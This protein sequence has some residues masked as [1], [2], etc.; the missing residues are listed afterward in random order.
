MIDKRNDG[1][2]R[3]WS[4][5]LTIALTIV[6]VF[7]LVTAVVE[8]IVGNKRLA[9]GVQTNPDNAYFDLVACSICKLPDRII[10]EGLSVLPNKGRSFFRGGSFRSILA[11]LELGRRLCCC[12]LY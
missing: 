4:V 5:A 3:L 11:Q 2:A 12:F 1:K 6:I 9:V 7:G 10:G 8:I